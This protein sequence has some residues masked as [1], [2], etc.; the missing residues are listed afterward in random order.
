MKKQHRIL[1]S[2][3]LLLVPIVTVAQ[4]N[5]AIHTFVQSIR[6]HKSMEVSF[7]YQTTGDLGKK[8]EAK[9]GKAYFQDEAYKIIME[10]QHAIS[11]GKTTWQ[12][13]VED[14]EV[15]VGNASDD[16]NPYQILDKLERDSSGLNPTFDP[17]GN[18]KKLEIEIDE[19]VKLVLNIKEIKF[20]QDFKK[21]FFSFDEK[22]HPKAEIIDMR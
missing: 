14:E 19:G 13:I 2:L 21:G 11:D 9:E 10:D 18:L 17:K 16:D 1:A 20:D 6:N 15:M 7:T 12:Y 8:E 22:A 5:N 3:L 4:N